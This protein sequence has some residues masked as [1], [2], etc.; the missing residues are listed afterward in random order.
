MG[1]RPHPHS[2]EC[3]F[4]NLKKTDPE[5]DRVEAKFKESLPNYTIRLIKRV[6]NRWLWVRYDQA[7]SQLQKKNG[8][9]VNELELF[10]GSKAP[11]ADI[12]ASEEGFDMRFSEQCLWGRAN[13]FAVK[14]YYS[15]HYAHAVSAD[16]KTQELILAKVLIG[17]SIKC[18]PDTTLRFPPEKQL[19][20][21][22]VKLKQVRYD[23]VNG[24][25]HGYRVYMTYSN[26]R[27]YPA[28]IITYRKP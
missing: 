23:S 15:H 1:W 12:C 20:R 21:S 10:H 27:A 17:D 11:A 24:V 9:L 14:A 3:I 18:D 4:V 26:D 19:N 8:V 2:E 7:R 6:Q 28:Y 25:T 16:A 13:Y 5:Y 22:R